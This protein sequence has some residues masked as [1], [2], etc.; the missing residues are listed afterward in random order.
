MKKEGER[1][2][3]VILL[4]WF[5]M[6]VQLCFLLGGSSE[7]E[8]TSV[9]RE[10]R[11]MNSGKRRVSISGVKLMN[12]EDDRRVVIDNGIVQVTL[13]RPEGYVVGISYNGIDN[14]LE[15]RNEE[16]DR[17]YFDVVWNKAG[18]NSTFQ[19]IHGTEFSIVTLDENEVEISFVRTW[20]SSMEGTDV[21]INIDQRYILRRGD[22]GFYSYT[23]FERPEGFPAVEVDQIRNVFKLREERFKYMAI[24]D[25]R[26][27][28]MPTK[29]DREGGQILAYPEAVLL[30][31][32]T[33]EDFRGE[34]D[35]KYQYSCENKDNRVHGWIS[36]DSEAPVGFWIITPSNEFRNAGPIKQDLTSH[37][38]PIAL[39]MFVS[40]HYAGK[41]ITMA[42]QE[43]ETYKKVFGP[44]FVYLNSVSTDQDPLTLWPDAVNQMS[45]EVNSWPYDFPQ[46]QDYIPPTQRGTVF[47]RLLVQDLYIRGGRFLHAKYAY[48]GLALPGPLGSWQ[49][50]SKGYQFWT[51][52]DK[53]GYFLIQNV[54]PGDYNL[55]AWLPGFIG[56]Y[57]YNA[58]I[59]ITPGCFIKLDSMVFNP[60]R[61]GPTLWEIGVPDRSAAEFY[62]PDPYPTLMNKLYNEQPKDKF[63]QY[64]LWERYADLY[65]NNDLLYTVGV[66]KYD[67]DWFYAQVTRSTGNRTYQPTTWQ[68]VFEHQND[69]FIGNYT[70]QLALA[71]ANDAELQVWINE[72]GDFPPQLD[73]GK[74]GR[75]SAIARHGIHGLY[76]LFSIDVPSH[77]LVKGKNTIYL[78]QSWAINPFQGV[79]YDYIRLERPPIIRT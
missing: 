68:I 38:G 69:I 37:V 60:P 31:N 25:Y 79:M 51:Q 10:L 46:S 29:E 39:S 35:D 1:R 66:D 42:F 64:G 9:R 56:D 74:I 20:T 62:I 11:E 59:T 34:V 44:I 24:S 19:R 15:P 65:P 33:N 77:L 36:F 73:T 71:S 14:V 54:V 58:T 21:P 4:W 2:K 52:A 8:K 49:K 16:Q 50:E 22:S 63:R 47:G 76:R 6:T 18:K 57:I 5:G 48:V 32:P 41:E 67:Q 53:K 13:S 30:T 12:E 26:Q 23:I 17:G 3:G 45:Q 55:F 72:I 40:T 27:R 7:I 28:W 43:G 70:L 78:K 75:D 61:N